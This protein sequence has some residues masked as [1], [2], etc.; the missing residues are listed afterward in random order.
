M[1]SYVFKGLNS[2]GYKSVETD[3]FTNVGDLFAQIII[4]GI[5]SQ[6]KRGLNRDYVI[7]TESISTI[8]GRV[9]IN[10]SL[11]SMSLQRNQLVCS[12]DEFSTNS[13]FNQIVKT[14][15]LLLLKSDIQPQRRR[16]L[17]RLLVY[18]DNV[19]IL[20]IKK[21]NWKIPYNRNNQ[22]YRLIIA[23][24]YLL[25]KGLIQSKRDGT[26][27]V[28]DFLDDQ[29][30]SHLYEKF[31]LAYYTQ[32]HQNLNSNASQIKWQLDDDFNELL[33]VMQTDITLDDGNNRY[34]IIDAK[35]YSKA[36]VK[37]H[38]KS[39]LRS[40]HLYQ[41]FAY[42]KNKEIELKDTEHTVSGMLL[43]AKTDEEISP[44]VSYKMSGN[45]ISAKTLDL[46]Q[47]FTIIKQQL[48]NIIVD[49]MS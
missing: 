41:I 16:D 35:Y 7:Q 13:H 12:F 21:I 8:R 40:G 15:V 20:D 22:N 44:D 1:L 5:K 46:N 14:S 28:M 27:K 30:L 36:M 39:I 47:E 32:E 6:L 23:I 45:T 42:V 25:I 10:E 43:Y 48:D 29:Y 24:C 19:D 17:R 33:P 31:I 26:V 11:K 37:S 9:D 18:F 49:Y 2:Q 38:D 3:S 4:L 34:L